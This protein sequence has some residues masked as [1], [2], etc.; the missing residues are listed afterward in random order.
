M[1]Q[2]TRQWIVD[3]P[4]TK[5][6]GNEGDILDEGK[7]NTA[8]IGHVVFMLERGH[9]ILFTAIDSDHSDDLELNPTPPHEGTHA[10]KCAYDC[11][12]LNSPD[13][14]DYAVPGGIVMNTFLADG[15]ECPYTYQVGEAGSAYT[16]ADVKLALGKHDPN[17]DFVFQD[18]GADH[19]HFG[20]VYL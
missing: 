4:H 1:S 13:P 16:A 9:I 12:P 19:V 20:T 3:H 5:F 2:Q 8:V 6:R 11:W 15:G 7:T 17:S 10:G 14:T 18:D